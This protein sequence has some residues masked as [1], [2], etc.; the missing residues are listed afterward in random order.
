MAVF[1]R[2]VRPLLLVSLVVL[3]L[4]QPF[5]HGLDTNSTTLSEKA[6]ESGYQ[7]GPER[8]V[9]KCSTCPCVKPCQ[10][11]PPPPPPPPSPPPPVIAQCTPPPSPP[12]TACC[13]PL[14]PPPPPRFVY[15]TDLPG[16]LYGAENNDNAWDYY[17]GG[18][19]I[20]SSITRSMLLAQ[21]TVFAVIMLL[22]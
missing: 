4:L 11:L 18:A 17:S 21:V 22:S 16:N 15:V 14:L 3:L 20:Y 6:E 7:L 9:V 1:S 12:V 19:P 13:I 2:E 5:S 8:G 10:Q